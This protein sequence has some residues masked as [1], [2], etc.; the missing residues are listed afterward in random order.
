MVFIFGGLECFVVG[1]CLAFS[2]MNG[3]QVMV[4]LHSKPYW[5]G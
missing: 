3:V 2:R 1:L 4:L 5:I